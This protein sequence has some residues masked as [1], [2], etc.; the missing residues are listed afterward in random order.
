MNLVAVCSTMTLQ[1]RSD[2]NCE[3]RSASQSPGPSE[4]M[5]D[6]PWP[7]GLNAQQ[8]QIHRQWLSVG[9][10]RAR[11]DGHQDGEDAVHGSTTAGIDPD[12][13]S[14][15]F[16]LSDAKEGSSGPMRSGEVTSTKRPKTNPNK[17]PTAVSSMAT[18]PGSTARKRCMEISRPMS[19]TPDRRAGE[20]TGYGSERDRRAETAS[21]QV[22]P[23][24]SDFSPARLNAESMERPQPRR[25]KRRRVAVDECD[26]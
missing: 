21:C 19:A 23:D 11:S 22:P 8:S 15:V 10:V 9:A 2:G 13:G 20:V 25:R 6:L 16:I 5:P 18:G 17:K 4:A 24:E 14:G 3:L 26:L 12:M 1:Q 7:Q